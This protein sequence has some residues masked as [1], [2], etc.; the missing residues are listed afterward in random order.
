MSCPD[1]FCHSEPA[2]LRC[3]YMD[4]LCGLADGAAL[5]AGAGR[6]GGKR[7]PIPVRRP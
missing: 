2:G 5:P 1:E 7:R 6:M 4:F 3:G